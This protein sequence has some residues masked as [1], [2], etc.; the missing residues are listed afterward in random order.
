LVDMNGGTVWYGIG[1]GAPSTSSFTITA[2]VS[3][4]GA[5][6]NVNYVCQP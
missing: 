3:V 4:S 2:G 5:T 6:F 1:N